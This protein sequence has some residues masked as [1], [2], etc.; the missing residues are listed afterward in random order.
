MR[1]RVFDPRCSEPDYLSTNQALDN[2]PVALHPMT[3]DSCKLVRTEWHSLLRA[4]CEEMIAGIF[5]A[6]QPE[7]G[8]PCSAANSAACVRP[9]T[10]S[11]SKIS[12]EITKR[13]RF[14]LPPGQ[15]IEFP[16]RSP[17]PWKEK[18]R[19]CGDAAL[20]SPLGSWRMAAEKV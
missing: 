8:Q 14:I 19:G 3:W 11:A 4:R 1:E 16:E 9:W 12:R 17:V 15:S 18:T 2:A 6:T 5:H 20:P 10:A 7:K 13:N